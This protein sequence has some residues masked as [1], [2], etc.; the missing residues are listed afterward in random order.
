MAENSNSAPLE[1]GAD[2]DYLEHERT[3]AGFV[4]IVKWAAV[5]LVALMIAMAVGFFVAGA[6]SA[7]I[8]FVLVCLAAWYIL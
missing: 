1:L 5:V 8:V 6:G 2:M 7:S 4:A 3:Y